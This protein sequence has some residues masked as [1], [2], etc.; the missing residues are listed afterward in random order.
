MTDSRHREMPAEADV[1]IIGG[2]VMGVSTAYHLAR[3]RVDR[4]VLLEKDELGEG[5]TARSAGGVR[6]VFSDEINI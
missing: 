2:G 4:V 3:S 5:S 6:A 1:V